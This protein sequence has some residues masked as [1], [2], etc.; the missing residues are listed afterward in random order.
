MLGF[1]IKN[2]YW[3]LVICNTVSI[4]IE[5]DLEWISKVLTGKFQAKKFADNYYE[6]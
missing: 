4:I 2:P 5:L 1:T 6:K 3:K